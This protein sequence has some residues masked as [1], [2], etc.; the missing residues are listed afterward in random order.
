ML[1]ATTQGSPEP[2]HRQH[3]TKIAPQVGGIDH[4]DHE[5]G[6]LLAHGPP[7]KHVGRDAFV[8]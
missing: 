8:R 2:P 7:E 5:I 3:Q 4:A 6:P 1:S